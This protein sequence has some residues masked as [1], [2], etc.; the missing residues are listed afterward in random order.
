MK[1]RDKGRNRVRERGEIGIRERWGITN[2][3]GTWEIE[4]DIWYKK[5]HM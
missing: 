1:G 4:K 5:Q 3:E 2:Y